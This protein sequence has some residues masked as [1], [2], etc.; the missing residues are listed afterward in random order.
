MKKKKKKK[1]NEKFTA[2][3]NC[4]TQNL[5]FVHF[6]LFSFANVPMH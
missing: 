2:M 4:S 5:E 3:C 1:K 6:I